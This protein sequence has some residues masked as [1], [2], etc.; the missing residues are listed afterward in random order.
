MPP[1]KRTRITKSTESIPSLATMH[2]FWEIEELISLVYEELDMCDRDDS[3]A[4]ML[5]LV[6]TRKKNF[7]SG[8][9]HIWRRPALPQLVR[10]CHHLVDAATS[11]ILAKGG[12]DRLLLY[13]R[14]IRILNTSRTLARHRGVTYYHFH[15]VLIQAGQRHVDLFPMLQQLTFD[16]DSEISFAT[17]SA[18]LRIT[19]RTLCVQFYPAPSMASVWDEGFMLLCSGLKYKCPRLVRLEVPILPPHADAVLLRTLVEATSNVRCFSL[20]SRHSAIM[21]K[22]MQILEISTMYPALEDLSV[23]SVPASGDKQQEPCTLPVMS[24]PCLRRVAIGL[25]EKTAALVALRACTS[26]LQEVI[27]NIDCSCHPRFRGTHGSLAS[28]PPPVPNTFSQ[29]LSEIVRA[30][31]ALPCPDLLSLTITFSHP[32]VNLVLQPLEPVPYCIFHPLTRF[33]KLQ[34]FKLSLNLG[35]TADNRSLDITDEDM[36]LLAAAWPEL[37]HLGVTWVQGSHEG[38]GI[39]NPNRLTFGGTLAPLAQGCPKLETIHISFLNAMPPI[40]IPYPRPCAN[41]KEI[42]VDKG[43]LWDVL[44]K[45]RFLLAVWPNADFGWEPDEGD[46]EVW[47]PLGKMLERLRNGGRLTRAVMRVEFP[48]TLYIH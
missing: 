22:P 14:H 13:S 34:T 2:R 25:S 45:G 29:V 4:D 24:F 47:K 6:L 26:S 44:E 11:P 30:I 33:S 21:I 43:R 18:A 40:P 28:Q 23:W 39:L 42:R 5:S 8:L 10:L 41:L 7:A 9:A 15:D 16:V 32:E 35:P 12:W 37:R 1:K 3:S 31:S 20:G 48:R 36:V 19:L 17:L 38:S 27:I 46:L